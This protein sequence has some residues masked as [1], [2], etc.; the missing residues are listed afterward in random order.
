[1]DDLTNEELFS[2]IEEH[3]KCTELNW[4][5]GAGISFDA[6]L[7]LMYPL[8]NKVKKDL[9]ADD[10]DV[11]DKIVAPLFTEL[12]Q[13]CHIEHIL[14]HLGDYAALAE[15][16]K[17][18]KISINGA[19]VTLVELQEAHRLILDSISNVI[20][21]GYVE[22]KAGNTTEQ[23]T[24]A[25][26]IVEIDSHLE[27][28]DTLFNHAGAGIYERRKSVNIFT[29]NYDTL[30]EDALAL[31]K[32]PYW[33]GFSGGAVAHRTQRYG[34]PLPTNGQR[35]NLIKMHGSIDWFLCEKGHVWRVRDNVRYPKADRRVLIYPQAT[36]Y[37]A[38]QQDPFSA[39][40][41][42]FRKALN[43][44]N[45]NVLAVC[46]YSFGD[47]HINNEIEFALS[48]DDNRTV[49]VAFL[50]C[51]EEIPSC[52]E[53]WR[54]SSYGSRVI[55]ASLHGLYVGAQGPFKRKDDDDYWWTFK[56]VTSVLKNGC[57][58]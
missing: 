4:L 37:I 35:A 28:V 46:G 49:L 34:E 53:R 40:F 9:K 17:D 42:L 31:N 54:K 41:D 18:K 24:I 1:M 10:Q 52:L 38:T 29:T 12:P 55:I 13:E 8:T 50:E 7:P 26:P 3:L 47:D 22:D 45:S 16:S 21:S 33:D 56:G 20:R 36:K 57:E 32:I 43:S 19:E 14:S 44:S 5:M 27:F 2:Q 51:R 48:K 58:V 25:E 6:K 39:Q 15:R 23:G 11:F 30:L